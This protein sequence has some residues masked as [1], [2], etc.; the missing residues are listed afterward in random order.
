MSP[1]EAREQIVK[2]SGTQFDPKIVNAFLKVFEKGEME[3]S[4]VLV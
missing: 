3:V 2:G 4:Q 1:Y